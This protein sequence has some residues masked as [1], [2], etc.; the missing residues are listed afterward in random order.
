MHHI[1]VQARTVIHQ[2]HQ[3][4]ASCV[5]AYKSAAPVIR[6]LVAMLDHDYLG[7]STSIVSYAAARELDPGKYIEIINSITAFHQNT[8]TISVKYIHDL[9]W[10]VKYRPCERA[11]YTTVREWI[12]TGSGVVLIEPTKDTEKEGRYIIL[13]KA[14]GFPVFRRV[15]QV[16]FQTLVKTIEEDEDL[17]QITLNKFQQY[18]TIIGPHKIERYEEKNA[19]GLL[20]RID[21]PTVSKPANGH[22]SIKLNLTSAAQKNFQKYQ[23]E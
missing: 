14:E 6:E 11:N 23:Q 13:C 17:K 1:E 16:M 22:H 9:Y 18:P 20:S 21:V 3:T 15:L 8:R 2:G 5:M 4:V 12:L 7:S 10:D 19:K